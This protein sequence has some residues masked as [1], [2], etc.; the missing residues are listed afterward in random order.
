MCRHRGVLYVCPITLGA[1][2]N[3]A[4]FVL[5]TSHYCVSA[6]G[7]APFPPTSPPDI[8]VVTSKQ[9]S[10]LSN[11]NLIIIIAASVLAPTILL[12]LNLFLICCCRRRLKERRK[13]KLLQVHSWYRAPGYTSQMLTSHLLYLPV[14][15]QLHARK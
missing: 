7:D 10:T 12:I 13:R 3:M 1:A 6:A 4:F 5:L 9:P 8:F 14:Y 15:K 2:G 11:T